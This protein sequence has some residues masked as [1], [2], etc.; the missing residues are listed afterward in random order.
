[1]MELNLI[2][3]AVASKFRLA[4]PPDYVLSVKGG[5]TLEFGDEVPVTVHAREAVKTFA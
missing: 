1:M 4:L 2:L 5:P 3:A